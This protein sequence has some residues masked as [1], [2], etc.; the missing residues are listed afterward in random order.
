MDFQDGFTAMNEGQPINIREWRSSD[1]QMRGLWVPEGTHRIYRKLIEPDDEPR[2]EQFG[3]AR[4]R[5]HATIARYCRTCDYRAALRHIVAFGFPQDGSIED[6]REI[7][8]RALGEE[9]RG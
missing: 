6:M 5:E 9:S 3:A 2:S 7:A 4:L 8:R 1:G